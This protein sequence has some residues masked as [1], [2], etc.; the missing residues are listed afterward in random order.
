M[1]VKEPP[2]RVLPWAISSDVVDYEHPAETIETGKYVTI[3]TCDTYRVD[4]E[5]DAMEPR[6]FC[7][8]ALRVHPSL[9][10]RTGADHLFYHAHGG[11]PVLARLIVWDDLNWYVRHF[12][13]DPERVMRLERK[14]WPTAHVV[15]GACFTA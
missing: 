2:G 12:N 3:P 8:D 14:Y 1:P 6:Y 5:T 11:G 9:P 4:V 7:G 15:M 10:P 13:P